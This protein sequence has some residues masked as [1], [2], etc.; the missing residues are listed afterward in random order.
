MKY[1]VAIVGGGL[2]GATLACALA[3]LGLSVA[4]VEPRTPA[5][6]PHG[7]FASRVS[8]ITR[9]TQH[10]FRALGVWE[11]L[12][13]ERVCAFREMHVWDIPRIGE[14]HFDSADIAEPGLGHIIENQVIQHALESRLAELDG[15]SWFR[16]MSLECLLVEKDVVRLDLEG[17]FLQ[18]TLAVGADGTASRVRQLCGIGCRKG[19]YGQHAVVATIRTEHDHGNIA[20]QRFLATG[21]LACLPL[22]QNHSAIVWSTVPDEAR[23]LVEM[24]QASFCEALEEA[25]ESRLGPV[26][27][28]G[29]R[30][31]FP[32]GW[33]HAE[34][35]VKE[36][37]VLVG[38]AA[39]TIHPLAGQGVNLG[40][41][42]IGVLAEVIEAAQARGRD[43][44][45]RLELRRYERWRRGHN[46]VMQTTM[47]GF[48]WLFGSRWPAL[49]SVRNLGLAATDRLEPV[50]RLIMRH[51]SGLAGDLPALARG[52]REG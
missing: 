28:A 38:D 8:A 17:T 3:R 12:D 21:P 42:D 25:F 48:H 34:Q 24:S 45:R 43:F 1:D 26:V 39:H 11:H 10:I 32:V 35:Y 29:G 40:F 22:P 4:I 46:A 5:A 33:M 44:S 37:V 16:P 47:D 50:K 36:R 52:R 49:R 6:K 20:W 41:Y 18:S 51:A 15:V 30:A 23:S 7:E 2:V 31:S 19:E 13:P 27:W 14:I 9:A